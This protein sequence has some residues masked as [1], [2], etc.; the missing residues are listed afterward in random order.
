M[1][2]DARRIPATTVTL[3][4]NMR[5]KPRVERWGRKVVDKYAA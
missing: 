4:G 1:P 2:L 5:R 3:G